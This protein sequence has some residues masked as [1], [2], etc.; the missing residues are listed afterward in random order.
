MKDNSSPFKR[1]ISY[2]F[3]SIVIFALVVLF[4]VICF[5]EAEQISNVS[6]IT[7]EGMTTR[8]DAIINAGD[9]D[10]YDENELSEYFLATAVQNDTQINNSIYQNYIVSNYDYTVSID[11]VHVGPWSKS[12][13]VEIHEITSSIT[14]MLNDTIDN[15]TLS[16]TPPNWEEKTYKIHL[17][18]DSTKRWYIEQME[19]ITK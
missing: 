10:K 13:T 3:R 7:I 9:P 1:A 8:A 18:R 16:R 14:G 17:R 12:A 11:K 15:D 19:Q 2:L 4:L 6:I 5:N